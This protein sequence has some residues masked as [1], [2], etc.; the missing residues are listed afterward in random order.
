MF[1]RMQ[2]QNK[3][4]FCPKNR[5]SNFLWSAG[6]TEKVTFHSKHSLLESNNNKK[7]LKLE[8]PKIEM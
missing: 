3:P 7:E 4:A 8:S 6:T 5:T 2:S 1:P